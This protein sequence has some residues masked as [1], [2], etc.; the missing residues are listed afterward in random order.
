MNLYKDKI[1][2]L[3]FLIST[4]LFGSLVTPTSQVFAFSK[5][6]NGFETITTNYLIPLS[7]AVAGSALILYVILSYFKPE[8][9]LKNIGMIVA[10][11]IISAVGLELITTLNQSFS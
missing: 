1:L 7:T 6:K 5:L 10:L 4:V 9:H 3:I 2:D 8:A 11:S